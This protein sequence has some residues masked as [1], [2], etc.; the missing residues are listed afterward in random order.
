MST[1]VQ[2]TSKA[3][4]STT[5]N[6]PVKPKGDDIFRNPNVLFTGDKDLQDKFYRFIDWYGGSN[7]H[8][9]PRHGLLSI[10]SRRINAY[11]VDH[12]AL[13]QFN[14]AFTTGEAI[15]FNA[16]YFKELLTQRENP[17]GAPFNTLEFVHSHELRHVMDYHFSRQSEHSPSDANIFQDMYIN[18]SLMRRD[19][20]QWHLP[21]EWASS[22]IGFKDDD[23]HKYGA[24]AEETIARRMIQERDKKLKEQTDKSPGDVT[25]AE[26]DTAMSSVLGQDVTDVDNDHVMT[27]EDF[28]EALEAAGGEGLLE[29]LG[30]PKNPTPQDIQDMLDKGKARIQN[31]LGEANDLR[32]NCVNGSKMAG[33]HIESE[34]Q[35]RISAESKPKLSVN[36]ALRELMYGDG[37]VTGY[38]DEIPDELYYVENAAMGLDHD[39]F[40]E[41]AVPQKHDAGCYL[42]IVDTSGSV[43]DD[44]LNNLFAEIRGVFNECEFDDVKLLVASADTIARGQ[45]LEMTTDNYETLMQELVAYGR[46]GTDLESGLNMSIKNAAKQYPEHKIKGIIYA[47]DLGDIPP[48]RDN[49]PEELPPVVFIAPSECMYASFGAGVEPWGQVVEISEGNVMDFDVE[50][51]LTP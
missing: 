37:M 11:L 44:M 34:I 41:G 33:G 50:T 40:L 26:K 45:M 12:P 28:I 3:S 25:D 8:G 10:M 18:L 31:D 6:A 21:K 32:N 23:Y 49:L 19:F 46:G 16:D 22:F 35:T 47:T 5:Q 38:I 15:F 9:L 27:M 1:T 13:A 39:I 17:D 29:K 2:P 36:M 43:I 14:T 20:P 4:E 48:N 7:E 42:F 24:L 51:A 30:L